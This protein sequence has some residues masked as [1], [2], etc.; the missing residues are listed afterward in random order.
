[1]DTKDLINKVKEWN[2]NLRNHSPHIPYT[3]ADEKASAAIIKSLKE[4]NTVKQVNERIMSFLD[5][6]KDNLTP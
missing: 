1:M 5:E 2:I 3:K 6:V 4:Y